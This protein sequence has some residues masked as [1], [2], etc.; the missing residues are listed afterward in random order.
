M[1]WQGWIFLLAGWSVIVAM[2]SFC[3]YRTLRGGA[4]KPADTPPRDA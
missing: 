3:L 2:L 4:G 1:T